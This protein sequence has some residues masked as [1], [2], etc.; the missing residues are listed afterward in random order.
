MAYTRRVFLGA[1][2][3]GDLDFFKNSLTACATVGSVGI[4]FYERT[5]N[6]WL[7]RL[8]VLTADVWSDDVGSVDDFCDNLLERVAGHAADRLKVLSTCDSYRGR[9]RDW[10]AGANQASAAANW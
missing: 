9:V 2:N 7:P 4:Y 6:Q 10:C 3:P 8:I 5:V 1:L